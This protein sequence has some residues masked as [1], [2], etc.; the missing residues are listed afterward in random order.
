MDPQ[1]CTLSSGRLRWQDEPPQQGLKSSSYNYTIL[2]YGKCVSQ[3]L[4]VHRLMQSVFLHLKQPST[5]SLINIYNK[6]YNKPLEPSWKRTFLRSWCEVGM[7]HTGL[8]LAQDNSFMDI[9]WMDMDSSFAWPWR[10][11]EASCGWCCLLDIPWLCFNG[12][13]ERKQKFLVHLAPWNRRSRLCL[14][15]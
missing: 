13:V 1:P 9:L 7:C 12:D 6:F 3:C 5:T 4:Q 15:L 11:T 10:H 14:Q 8:P 2:P